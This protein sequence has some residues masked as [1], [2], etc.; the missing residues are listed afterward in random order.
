VN[1]VPALKQADVG[2]AIDLKGSD[3]AKESAD[4]VPL[5]DNFLLTN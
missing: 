1:N 3:V 4:I 5:D 2:I